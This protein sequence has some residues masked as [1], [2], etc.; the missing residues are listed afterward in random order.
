M[1]WTRRFVVL[2]SAGL[3]IGTANSKS[4][5]D[6]ALQVVY[7]HFIGT[8]SGTDDYRSNRGMVTVPVAITISETKNQKALKLDYVYSKKGEKDYQHLVR[9]MA[10]DPVKGTVTL[11]WEHDD[12]EHYK[13]TG[14]DE[15]MK[16]GYG[17]FGFSIV[18]LPENG[19]TIVDSCTLQ[20]TAN[21]LS[22]TWGESWNEPTSQTTG[23]WKL[24]R[25]LPPQ[26][27]SR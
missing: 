22:Y 2:L 23:A 21:T 3:L 25:V 27:P 12:K 16:T 4:Q 10:I 19:V 1:K 26:Q 13:T 17:T 24:S 20:L 11:N 15:F 9:F 14:L 18:M 7:S 8:W 6:P 5:T